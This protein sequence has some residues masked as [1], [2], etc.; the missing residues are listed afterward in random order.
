MTRNSKLLR[1]AC[2]W[3]AAGGVYFLTAILT[4]YD[5][6]DTIFSA[7]I[8]GAIVSTVTVGLCALAGLIFRLPA[9]ARWRRSSR[10]PMIMLSIAVAIDGAHSSQHLLIFAPF[11]HARWK[12]R[13]EI[14][15]ADRT[16]L[17]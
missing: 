3:L 17:A 6:I 7:A 1:Y 5:G 8:F 2:A 16:R 9:L 15:P 13:S 10:A 11:E 12:A 14:L 4:A